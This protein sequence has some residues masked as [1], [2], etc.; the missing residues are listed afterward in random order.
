MILENTPT[1]LKGELSRWL[2]E[3]KSGV[4]I[5]NPSARI[6]DRLWQ[7]AIEKCKNGGVLQ[8]WTTHSPQGFSY[9]YYGKLSRQI[10]DIEGIALVSIPIKNANEKSKT[11]LNPKCQSDEKSDNISCG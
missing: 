3:P 11:Q 9:R 10:V 4:F 8:I 2:I 7:K 5:G 1:N 6:R